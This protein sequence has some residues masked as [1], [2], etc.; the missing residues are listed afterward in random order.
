VSIVAAEKLE[1]L[2]KLAVTWRSLAAFR[3]KLSS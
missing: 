1:G 2:L 3:K